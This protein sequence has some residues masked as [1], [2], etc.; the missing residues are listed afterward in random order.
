MRSYCVRFYKLS[1]QRLSKSSISFLCICNND[2]VIDH[3]DLSHRIEDRRKV[4]S[5]D[6]YVLLTDCLS[7]PN[8][9]M[10]SVVVSGRKA[11]G[12]KLAPIG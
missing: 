3:P 1:I 9:Y 8:P 4:L 11:F 5:M 12:R 7:P 2:I 6:E 10:S